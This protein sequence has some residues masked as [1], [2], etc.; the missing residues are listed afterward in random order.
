MADSEPNSIL[1]NLLALGRETEWVERKRA[2]TS[3]H[4][5]ELGRYF[6]A[7]SNEA[8]LHGQ[9]AGWLIFGVADDG[10]LAG[11][12]YRN[13]SESLDAL[14]HEVTVQVS[15]RLTFT[16]IHEVHL[17][18]RRILLFRIPPAVRGM[19]TAWK[20]HY[21]GRD[22]E[23]LVPLNIQ[24]LEAIRAQSAQEDWTAALCEDATLV[25]LHPD[26]IARA[27]AEFKRKT[28]TLSGEVDNWDD[29]TFLNKA[30]LTIDGRITRAAILL[31]G[32]PEAEHCLLPGVGTITWV[33]KTGDNIERDYSHFGAA[34]APERGG[35]T[36]KNPQSALSPYARRSAISFGS[37]PI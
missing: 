32:K 22:G 8:N 14:K 4:F 31:L 10:G 9:E 37:E 1:Y 26:A 21:Y 11:T 15:N 3:F 17:R 30:R 18:G 7:L 6:S 13:S 35:C 25:H 2:E 20:G 36:W 34:L 19:P 29:G 12:S 16:A 27:R 24:E 28:P 23:S 5:D 33:L